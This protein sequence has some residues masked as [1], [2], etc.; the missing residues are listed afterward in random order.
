M[1]GRQHLDLITHTWGL[2]PIAAIDGARTGLSAAH[3]RFD[4]DAIGEYE[5][6]PSADTHIISPFLNGGSFHELFL[7]D[8]CR[9]RPTNVRGEVFNL[10]RAG[11]APRAII[12]DAHFDFLHLYL[13][14]ALL[15]DWAWWEADGADVAVELL[16]V[17]IESDPVIARL[18]TVLMDEMRV[19][20]PYARLA[21]D[22]LTQQLVGHMLRRWSNVGGTRQRPTAPTADWR[23][24][25]AME[26]LAA[27][28]ADEPGIADLAHVVGL[29]PRHLSTLF[30][31]STGL[32][33]HQWLVERRIDRARD[34]LRDRSL[35]MTEVALACGFAS[36]QHFATTFRSRTGTTP[37]AFRR[38]QL[39]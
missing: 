8:R 31:R 38:D 32:S 12:A 23:L 19:G 16:P 18:A 11:E 35:S 3:W 28:L 30:R 5:A 36:S 20:A 34:M 33:P 9:Y 17:G 21:V 25:R 39:P 1:T 7:D 2:P 29:S 6:P 26:H 22:A 14:H 13:P 24:R 37:S 15:T 4:H 27:H 10:V